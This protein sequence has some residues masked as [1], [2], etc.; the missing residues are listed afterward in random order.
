VIEG[1]IQA[2]KGRL[3]VETLAGSFE[4]S[5]PHPHAEGENVELLLRPQ[6]VHRVARAGLSGTVRDV[7]FQRNL[8]KVTFENGLYFY[9]PEAPR[10]GERICLEILP[11]ALEC[12]T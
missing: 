3:R 10:I 9:L 2:E 7:I 1:K 6:G 11:S 5:C 8:F 12:L 4:M